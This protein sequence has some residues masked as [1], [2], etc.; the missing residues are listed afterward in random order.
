MSLLMAYLSALDTSQ[1]VLSISLKTIGNFERK[2][3][4]QNLWVRL[5]PERLLK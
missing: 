4:F 2:E 5:H 1:I 3:Q